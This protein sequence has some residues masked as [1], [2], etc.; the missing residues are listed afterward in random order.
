MTTAQPPEVKAL[1]QG[2][3]ELAAQLE[4]GQCACGN[5]GQSWFP[6]INSI[7]ASARGANAYILRGG[8]KKTVIHT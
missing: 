7:D 4:P 3:K 8:D 5:S 6:G 1:A 2:S